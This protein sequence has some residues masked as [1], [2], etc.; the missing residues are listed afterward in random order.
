MSST[1]GTEDSKSDDFELKF[2]T[3]AS[4]GGGHLDEFDLYFARAAPSS[5]PPACPH[6]HQHSEMS[7]IS[8]TECQLQVPEATGGG[9]ER[10]EEKQL[11]VQPHGRHAD[12]PGVGELQPLLLPGAT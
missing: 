9:G 10:W 11:D 4:T 1:Q 12:P 5:H 7:L 3:G 6:G 8:P 2:P